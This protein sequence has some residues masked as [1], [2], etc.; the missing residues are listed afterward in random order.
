MDTIH[1]THLTWADSLTYLQNCTTFNV[2]MINVM[3]LSDPAGEVT[4][5]IRD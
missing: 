5:V 1:F 2:Y 4:G 3:Y